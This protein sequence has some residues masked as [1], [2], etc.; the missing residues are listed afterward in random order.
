MESGAR[1]WSPRRKEGPTGPSHHLLSRR[2]HSGRRVDGKQSWDLNPGTWI[3][4]THMS[5]G[6]FTRVHVFSSEQSGAVWRLGQKCRCHWA[7][8]P[9]SLEWD[10]AACW[11]PGFARSPCVSTGRPAGEPP[12]LVKVFVL[13][14]T[15]PPVQ[16][17]NTVWAKGDL[18]KTHFGCFRLFFDTGA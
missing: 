14:L 7:V 13:R 12:S 5:S 10:H 4:D 2:V 6:V 1:S 9:G 11:H 3:R 8:Q 17:R 18:G 15:P 16:Q